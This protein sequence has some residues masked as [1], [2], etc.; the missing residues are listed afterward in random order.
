[1]LC[2][3]RDVSGAPDAIRAEPILVLARVTNAQKDRYESEI[4]GSANR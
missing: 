4:R 1:M 3:G 2:H